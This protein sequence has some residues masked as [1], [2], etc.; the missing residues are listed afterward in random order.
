MLAAG[1]RGN[2]GAEGRIDILAGDCYKKSLIVRYE[3][4]QWSPD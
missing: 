1:L 2:L 3:T 4:R